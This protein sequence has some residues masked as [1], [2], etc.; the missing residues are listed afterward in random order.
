MA[1]LQERVAGLGA[2]ATAT[3]TASPAASDV[4]EAT[5]AKAPGDAVATPLTAGSNAS[6]DVVTPAGRAAPSP[7][8][9]GSPGTVDHNL[10]YGGAAP[11]PASAVKVVATP[12]LKKAAVAALGSELDELTELQLEVVIAQLEGQL[13]SLETELNKNRAD[14]VASSRMQKD[15]ESRICDLENRL[16]LTTEENAHLQR[17]LVEVTE[18]M[19]RAAIDAKGS[20]IAHLPVLMSQLPLLHSP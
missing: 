12:S 13:V 3:A 5:P 1:E 10:A 16:Q 8:T 18:A 17:F 6:T 15:Y 4:V 7:A 2:G 20:E 14:V 11:A 19:E 9:A